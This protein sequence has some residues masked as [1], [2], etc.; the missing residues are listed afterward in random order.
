M[1]EEMNRF[2]FRQ[3]RVSLRWVLGQ[4]DGKKRFLEWLCSPFVSC[5]HCGLHHRQF[6]YFTTKNCRNYKINLSWL[7]SVC[8]WHFFFSYLLFKGL[9]FCIIFSSWR[10]FAPQWSGVQSGI[11]CPVITQLFKRKHRRQLHSYSRAGSKRLCVNLTLEFFKLFILYITIFF[12]FCLFSP[13]DFNAFIYVTTRT[14]YLPVRLSKR[15]KK[16]IQQKREILF[17]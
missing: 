17:I 6:L 11:S 8:F 3:S 15:G 12:F 16:E 7:L 1:Y 2:L 13:I 9:G 10:R 14:F 5:R 4:H